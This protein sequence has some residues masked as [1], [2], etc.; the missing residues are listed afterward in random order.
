MLICDE[1]NNYK[2]D[3]ICT[4]IRPHFQHLVEIDDRLVDIILMLNKK[5]YSTRFCCQG[6]VNDFMLQLHIMFWK[7][8]KFKV[9]PDG[10]K[11]ITNDSVNELLCLIKAKDWNKLTHDERL[12]IIDERINALIE[13][14][15]QL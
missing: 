2:N 9:I 5:G 14:A 15:Y 3:C 7:D 10:F 6:H 1:C 11:F 4:G 12:L 13:W 8:H